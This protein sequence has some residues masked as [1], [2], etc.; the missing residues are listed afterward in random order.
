MRLA[1]PDNF[2]LSTLSVPL[3]P[4]CFF[5]RANKRTPAL[6]ASVYLLRIVYF[7][8]LFI[9]VAA[10]VIWICLWMPVL[11]K[12]LLVHADRVPAGPGGMH[13]VGTDGAAS[14]GDAD[15]PSPSLRRR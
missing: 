15:S 12:T 11:R 9:V 7:L 6:R 14:M 10:F 1:A 5:C 8:Q 2:F 4:F 13:A 3:Q